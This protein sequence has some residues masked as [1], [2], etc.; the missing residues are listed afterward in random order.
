MAK[1]RTYSLTDGR[2]YIHRLVT[3]AYEHGLT[4]V[5]IRWRPLSTFSYEGYGWFID[6]NQG[7]GIRLGADLFDAENAVYRIPFPAHLFYT[8]ITKDVL[9]AKSYHAD[10]W[11]VNRFRDHCCKM[12]NAFFDLKKVAFTP[13]EFYKKLGDPLLHRPG[14]FYANFVLNNVLIQIM[15]I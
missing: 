14:T 15:Y 1:E 4:G 7:K 8:E 6:C 3:I 9:S 10:S 12:V 11:K 13:A 2:K 5:T